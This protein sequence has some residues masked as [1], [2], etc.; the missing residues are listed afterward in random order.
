[1]AAGRAEKRKVGAR[2]STCMERMI[3]TV[4]FSR[5]DQLALNNQQTFNLINLFIR[6]SIVCKVA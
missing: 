6:H 2:D 3:G 5:K 1:M 4:F